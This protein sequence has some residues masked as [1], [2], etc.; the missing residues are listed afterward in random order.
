MPLEPVDP[1]LHRMPQLVGDRIEGR[2]PAASPAPG[3]P[4]GGLVVLL[5]N[6][7]ADAAAAQVRPVG[8]GTVGLVGQHPIGPGPWPARAQA[9]HPDARKHRPELRAVATLPG[10]DHDRQRAL[11][12]LDGQVQLAAQPTPGAAERV[13]GGLDVD[14]AWFFALAVPPLRAPAAC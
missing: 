9:R 1:A 13:V 7:G 12:T 4:V 6:G 10:G 3:A 8:A 5:G 11:A 2:R 14:S